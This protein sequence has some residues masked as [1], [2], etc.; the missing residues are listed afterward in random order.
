MTTTKRWEILIRSLEKTREGKLKWEETPASD[1]FY[2]NIGGMGLSI[3]LVSSDFILSL[4]NDDG[5]VVEAISDSDFSN[6]GFSGAFGAMKE[7]YEAARAD[8]TGS[9]KV[10]DSILDMLKDI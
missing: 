8:A 7:L 9:E 6:G 3:R 2:C 1:M 4:Y 5:E 10:A